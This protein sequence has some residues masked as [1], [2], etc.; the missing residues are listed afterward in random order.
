VLHEHIEVSNVVGIFYGSIQV[1]H[2]HG[3]IGWLPLALAQ[4]FDVADRFGILA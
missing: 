3:A 1:S 4:P 2:Q